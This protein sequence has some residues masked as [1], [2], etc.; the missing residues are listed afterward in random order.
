MLILSHEQRLVSDHSF[1]GARGRHNAGDLACPAIGSLRGPCPAKPGK[2]RRARGI[3]RRSVIDSDRS[4]I[5]APRID[6]AAAK[7]PDV[8]GHT[9]VARSPYK[10]ATRLARIRGR[11]LDRSYLL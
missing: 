1:P 11:S 7:K 3:A 6:P 8:R 9:D 5:C 10:T 2:K 4:S